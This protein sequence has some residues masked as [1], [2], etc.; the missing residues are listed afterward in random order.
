MTSEPSNDET[1]TPDAFGLS[2]W[3]AHSLALW[4][5]TVASPICLGLCIWKPPWSDGI[6]AVTVAIFPCALMLLGASR[7]GRGGLALWPIAI[8]C[9]VL[10]ATMAGLFAFR[11][12]GVDGPMWG[13]LPVAAAVQLYGLFL[14]PLVIT[15]IGYAAS[16]DRWNLD[17]DALEALRREFEKP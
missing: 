10:L 7:Q 14:L 12:Q 17:E 1:A 9:G 3:N 13:G 11:S 4:T 6:F 16:F 8:L 5:L 2:T 15:S